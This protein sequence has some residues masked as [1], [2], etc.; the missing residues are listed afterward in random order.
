MNLT[1]LRLRVQTSVGLAGGT[2]GNEQTLIDG[3]FNEAVLQFLVKTKAVK[4]TASLAMTGGVGDYT[5]DPLILAFEDPYIVPSTGTSYMLERMDSW[6]IRQMRL[7]AVATPG[8]PSY[9]DYE[10]NLLLLYPAPATGDTLHFVYVPKPTAPIA[11]GADSPSDDG[12]GEIPEE[13]HPVLESYVLWKAAQYSNDGPSQF[14]QLYAAQWEKGLMDA[15]LNQSRKAGVK[16]ARAT[17]GRQPGKFRWA[18]P[19][20]DTGY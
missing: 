12:K 8:P 15:K 17:I 3:W 4:K 7:V 11:T 16:Q 9:Y 1:T 5:V 19:G 20:V 13:Y 14:G 10:G 2:A 6:D 18:P